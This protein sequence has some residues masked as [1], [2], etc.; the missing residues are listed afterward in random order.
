VV[1]AS[2]A[3]CLRSPG[4]LAEAGWRAWRAGK[5]ADAVTLAPIYLHVNEVIPA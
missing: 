5:T 1:L 2:P 3:A 4:Y